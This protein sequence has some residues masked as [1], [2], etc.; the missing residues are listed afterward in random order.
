MLS[1]H[2]HTEYSSLITRSLS[3][4]NF[5]TMMRDLENKPRVTIKDEE[6]ALTLP[7]LVNI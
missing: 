2:P 6:K 4:L 5:Q 1:R 3:S 7:S